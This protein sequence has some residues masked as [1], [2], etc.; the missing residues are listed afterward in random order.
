[1]ERREEEGKTHDGVC[2]VRSELGEAARVE[3]VGRED[4]A[5]RG[6]CLNVDVVGSI[7]RHGL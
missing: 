5:Q 3:D 6:K 2:R 1:M 7:V 4:I